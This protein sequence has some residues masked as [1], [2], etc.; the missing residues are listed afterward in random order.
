MQVHTS[1]FRKKT[2][3]DRYLNNQHLNNQHPAI[4]F[5]VEEER[6]GKIPFLDVM[7]ERKGMQVH[8]SVFRKKTHTDRYL[9]YE[10]HHH[11]RTLNGVVKCLK[12]R[13][14]EVC[15]PPRRRKK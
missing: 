15:H 2:H 3:T 6:E 7:V 11:P 14:E 1:V 12:N 9:N 4:Q 5:T 13:A 10:S 8:T